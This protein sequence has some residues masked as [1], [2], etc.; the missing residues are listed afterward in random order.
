MSTVPWSRVAVAAPRRRRHGHGDR[1]TRS[2]VVARY[3]S[4]NKPHSCEQLNFGITHAGTQHSSARGVG[5]GG[6]LAPVRRRAVS[7]RLQLLLEGEHLL[8]LRLELHAEGGGARERLLGHRA[9]PGERALRAARRRRRRRQLRRAL[10]APRV[11]LRQ[12]QVLQAV[13]Y[14]LAFLRGGGADGGRSAAGGGRGRARRSGRERRG[15]GA[16]R[17]ARGAAR[18]CSPSGA[19]RCRRF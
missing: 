12:A 6:A 7:A 11:V 15:R 2:T 16:G 1:R 18:G 19:C 10:A 5:G 17:C 8:A 9:H 13:L 14:P 4:Q 3:P